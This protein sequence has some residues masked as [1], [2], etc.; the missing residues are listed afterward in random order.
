MVKLQLGKE[1]FYQYFILVE[2][3]QKLE[4]KGEFFQGLVFQGYSIGWKG[5]VGS[6][7][8]YNQR[9]FSILYFVFIVRVCFKRVLYL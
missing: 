7:W 1:G 6:G 9:I 4:D 2:F 3:Y 5:G 8:R